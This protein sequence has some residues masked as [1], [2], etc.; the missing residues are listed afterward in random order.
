MRMASNSGLV[1]LSHRRHA[2]QEI[3][4]ALPGFVLAH[5][6]CFSERR[7]LAGFVVNERAVQA[8]TAAARRLR[9]DHAKDTQVI[10][11]RGNTGPRDV[12]NHL[13]DTVD[14]AVALRALAQQNIGI[15]EFR[16]VIR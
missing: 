9:A 13:T 16:N 7:L 8:T 10:L 5:W 14:F 6:P 15:L 3:G 11:D 4:D 1:L 2:L 12:A